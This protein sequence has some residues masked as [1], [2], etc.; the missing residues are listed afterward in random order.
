MKFNPKLKSDLES[1]YDYVIVVEGQKDV[2][3]MQALGF[4]KVFAI[5]QT[6]I[7]IKE[8]V[9][10]IAESMDKRDK[11]CILT[12]FDKRGKQLYMLLKSMFQE[13]GVRLDSTLRGI[14]LV[15]GVSHVEGMYQF[16]KKAKFEERPKTNKK[17]WERR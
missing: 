13:Q 3:A 11:L 17:N 7:P 2:N 15:A 6:S 14:L 10:E 8:R 5:H 1:F 16:Y 12:D 4:T 9:L